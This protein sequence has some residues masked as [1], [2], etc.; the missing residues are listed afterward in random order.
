MKDAQQIHSEKGLK[1][2][3]NIKKRQE[4]IE[5]E[6]G[7]RNVFSDLGFE[8]AEEELLKSDLTAEVAYI[9]KKKKLTQTKAA[10]ILGVDQP[11]ISS[12]LRGRLDLFL[13]KH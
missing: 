7:S 3:T 9:I 12:L 5:H 10:K 13:W 11:R 2:K 1:M 8:N 4:K 6:I